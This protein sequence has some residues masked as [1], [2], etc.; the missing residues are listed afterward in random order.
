MGNQ[1]GEQSSDTP[2][3]TDRQNV[4]GPVYGSRI[5]YGGVLI[6]QK[7]K[8]GHM[9]PV[10][11]TCRPCVPGAVYVCMVCDHVFRVYV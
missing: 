5:V 2:I 10:Q 3:Q 6:F 4:A 8:W 9:Q 1:M 7:L 11:T